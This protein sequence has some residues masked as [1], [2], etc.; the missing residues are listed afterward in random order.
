MWQPIKSAPRSYTPILLTQDGVVG[1]GW[2]ASHSRTWEFASSQ[3]VMKRNP[4][5]WMPLPEP[6]K[7][8]D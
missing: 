2:H 5:H 1:E 3:N 4:T 8:E 6:P 7:T